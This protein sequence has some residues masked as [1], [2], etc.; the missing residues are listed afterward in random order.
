MWCYSSFKFPFLISVF[1]QYH[2]NFKTHFT[3]FLYQIAIAIVAALKK[4]VCIYKRTCKNVGSLGL[5]L[6]QCHHTLHLKLN[7][8]SLAEQRAGVTLQLSREDILLSTGKTV[9]QKFHSFKEQSNH[10]KFPMVAGRQQLDTAQRAD[11]HT[12]RVPSDL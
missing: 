11:H 3:S 5:E 4:L 12:S 2:S 1:P 7:H 8:P 10:Y 6:P 9:W